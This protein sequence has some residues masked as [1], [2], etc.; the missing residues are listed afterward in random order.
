MVLVEG[1]NPL[2]LGPW[3][4]LSG[5]AAPLLCLQPAAVT[6]AGNAEVTEEKFMAGQIEN[7]G[8]G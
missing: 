4:A 5:E 7:E 1:R 2:I 6:S 8:S 3:S